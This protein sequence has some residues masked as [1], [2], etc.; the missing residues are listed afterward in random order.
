MSNEGITKLY[1]HVKVNDPNNEICRSLI[2]RQ[3][4]AKTK[5]DA[6]GRIP[7]GIKKV[8]LNAKN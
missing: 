2:Q 4:A 7:L 3:S 8:K 6:E 5:C 1:P